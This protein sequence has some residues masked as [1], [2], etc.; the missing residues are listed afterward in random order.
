MT[1]EEK[2]ITTVVMT[3]NELKQYAHAYLPTIA[4]EIIQTLEEGESYQKMLEFTNTVEDFVYVS[5]N[6]DDDVVFERTI[7]KVL[8]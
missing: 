6:E 5:L 4:I 2:T 3:Q 7:E 8:M 1:M